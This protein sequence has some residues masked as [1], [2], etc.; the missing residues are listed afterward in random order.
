MRWADA[1]HV[2]HL[3]LLRLLQLH[4][5]RRRLPLPRSRLHNSFVGDGCICLGLGLLRSLP[6]LQHL[7]LCA[8]LLQQLQDA[9][10]VLFTTYYIFVFASLSF[11]RS[12]SKTLTMRPRRQPCIPPPPSSTKAASLRCAVNSYYMLYSPPRIRIRVRPPLQLLHVLVLLSL[13]LLASAALH[14]V[15]LL[16]N[17]ATP[18]VP[19]A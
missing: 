8:P 16:T 19:R 13:S 9:V 10:A 11:V 17:S 1:T 15:E 5:M 14:A 7:F 3:H 12:L 2:Q 18:G 6:L 4:L